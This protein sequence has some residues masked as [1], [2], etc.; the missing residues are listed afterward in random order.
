MRI[1]SIIIFS[2]ASLV[3]PTESEL[4][5]ESSYSG[6]LIPVFFSVLPLPCCLA[7]GG[8]QHVIAYH[9][10]AV[11]RFQFFYQERI[12]ILTYGR[13]QSLPPLHR[14]NETKNNMGEVKENKRKQA[15]EVSHVEIKVIIWVFKKIYL[16]PWPGGSA[17]WTLSWAPEG[18]R[19]MPGQC[20]CGRQ[21]SDIFHSYQCLSV[22]LSFSSPHP[23][24]PLSNQ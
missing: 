6:L 13:V 10:G 16:H 21:L 20:L 1:I 7:I 11:S 15:Y 23:S 18:C 3:Y 12:A 8:T 2:S 19:L 22:C 5:P 17:C 14:K 4:S 9:K 24:P